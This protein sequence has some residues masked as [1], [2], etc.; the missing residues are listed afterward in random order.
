MKESR[1]GKVPGKFIYR[2]EETL[3]KH[4]VRETA[5]ASDHERAS[6]YVLI[7]GLLQIVVKGRHTSP[8]TGTMSPE[9]QLGFGS[10]RDARI[11]ATSP[12]RRY[13]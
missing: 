2:L 6:D 5:P 12:P 7:M 9:K 1:G 3:A 8:R 4:S 10:S 11:K 13:R